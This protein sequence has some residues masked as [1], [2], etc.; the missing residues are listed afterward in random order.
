M[1][2]TVNRTSVGGARGT[3]AGLR[4]ALTAQQWIARIKPSA[5]QQLVVRNMRM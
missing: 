5:Q 4:N 1:S 2:C 3:F